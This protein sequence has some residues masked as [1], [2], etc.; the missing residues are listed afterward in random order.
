MIDC[1]LA[2]IHLGLKL[3]KEHGGKKVDN[4]LYKQI[5]GT[6]MY[7][8]LTRPNIM[9]SVILICGTLTIL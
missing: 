5:V 6:L 2:P 8:T 4:I 3:H 1:N 7:L 9:C